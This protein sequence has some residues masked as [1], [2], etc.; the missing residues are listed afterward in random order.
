M[1][2]TKKEIISLLKLLEDPDE[3]VYQV[4]KE[5]I[6]TN[7]EFFK[8]YLENFHSL[9][10]N[11]LA[12]ERSEE[13]LDEIFITDFLKELEKFLNK[14][15]PYL[16]EGVFLFET[17]FNRDIDKNQ[18]EAYYDELQR[19][20]WMEF[21]DNLTSIEKIRVLNKI[22]FKEFKFKKYPIG[23][24]NPDYLSITSCLSYRKFIAPSILLLYSMLAQQNNIPLYP[25][26]IP[27]IFLMAF[28]MKDADKNRIVENSNGIVFFIHPFD[29]GT[30]VG[31]EI[32]EK[33]LKDN[34]IDI[35]IND[36]SIMTYLDFLLFYFQL[37]IIAIEHKKKECFE[38]KYA[39]RVMNFYKSFLNSNQE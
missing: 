27:G 19:A 4:I 28:Y 38:V 29:E 23:D 16:Y 25:V 9:S 24:F 22:I 36:I 20:L 5:R 21:N 8:I 10:D 6:M 37:R 12:I 39:K 1:K 11:S 18:L 34:K 7:S 33:Y 35:N 14:E 13:I 26:K 30:I 3:K 31:H 17:Y 15:N 2:M 32:I